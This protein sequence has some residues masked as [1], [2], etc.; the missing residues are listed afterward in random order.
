MIRAQRVYLSGAAE[1]G[2]GV[3]AEVGLEEEGDSVGVED[4]VVAGS[5][6]GRTHLRCLEA[7]LGGPRRSLP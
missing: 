1:V 5:E 2:L 4:S 3:E 7:R 6:E